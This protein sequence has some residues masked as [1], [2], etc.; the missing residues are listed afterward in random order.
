MLQNPSC[1]AKDLVFFNKC[2]AIN[3]TKYE[4]RMLD[5]FKKQIHNG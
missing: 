5:C 2:A 1:P 4:G 3:I